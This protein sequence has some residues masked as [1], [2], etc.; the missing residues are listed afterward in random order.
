MLKTLI[1]A[2]LLSLTTA[3]HAQRA[4]ITGNAE[5]KGALAVL[6]TW[7]QAQLGQREDP[8]LS[9]GIVYD[10]E[11]V[12]S[13]G[14]GFA[15]LGKRTPT[16]VTT[17]Y[18]L[19]SL[20][21]LF[22]AT[23]IMQLRDAGKLQLDDPVEK[24]LAWFKIKQPDDAPPITIRELLTHSSGMSRDTSVP[25]WNEFTFPTHDELVRLTTAEP[26][27]FA[28]DAQ[29]KYSNLAL[30]I[31]GEV[32]VAGSGEPYEQYV[33][34]HILDP[35]G[36]KSTLVVPTSSS[37][38]IAVGYRKRVPGKPREA[39]D[40]INFKAYTPAAGFASNVEDL[41]RLVALQFR[42]ATATGPQVLRPSTVR[43]MH[44]VHFLRPDWQT[45][46]GL[47]WELRHVSE[48]GAQ[49]VYVEKGGTCPGYRSEIAMIVPQKLGVIVLLNGYDS[50]PVFY[51][52][53]VLSV[54]SPI[55]AKI[56]NDEKPKPAPV[57][58]PAWSKYVGTYTWKHNDAEIMIID[59]QLMMVAPESNNPWDAKVQLIPTGK[60]NRFTQKGGSNDGEPLVFE[61]DSSGRAVRFWSGTYYRVR[62]T[63]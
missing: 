1:F 8:G 34:R 7:F 23:A 19:A 44:R 11:L 43:E 39:E 55:V 14:Y 63:E 30:A 10:Q 13:K 15:D 16:T 38:N 20:S 53:Q 42:G 33:Q 2:I 22:T 32:V 35:L 36:M 61:I 49:Q 27:A 37:P 46:M 18:R 6:D 4:P 47:A 59:G 45:A 9:V 31:A 58:D 12:W 56:Q 29:Y 62:K 3:G 57:A 28:P 41:T 48:K 17:R 40:F 60:P 5:I 54:L 50:D 52:N 51:A 24:H 26:A 25:M 21:K